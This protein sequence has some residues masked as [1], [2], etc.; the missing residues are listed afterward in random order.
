[1]ANVPKPPVAWNGK[2]Y[3]ICLPWPDV[4]RR[5]W[6]EV[7]VSLKVTYVVR[8]RELGREQWLVGVETPLTSCT[9]VEL[10]P[11]TEYEMEVRAKSAAGESDPAVVTCRTG[12]DGAVDS[13]AVTDL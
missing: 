7:E 1:M 11:N 9:L 5:P 13:L 3:E 10:K 2:S 12:P 8:V 6:L 4:P